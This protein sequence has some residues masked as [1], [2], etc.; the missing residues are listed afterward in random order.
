MTLLAALERIPAGVTVRYLALLDTLPVMMAQAYAKLDPDLTDGFIHYDVFKST[1]N[2]ITY[3]RVS[4][5]R[6]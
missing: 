2:T 5:N 4:G 1:N 3:S 6:G